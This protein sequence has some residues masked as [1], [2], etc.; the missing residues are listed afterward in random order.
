MVACVTQ[1]YCYSLSSLGRFV[2]VPPVLK[3]K[4]SV[5]LPLVFVRLFFRCIFVLDVNFSF[6]E[7]LNLLSFLAALGFKPDSAGWED[8][9]AHTV[10]WRC[11]YVGCSW[12]IRFS[13]KFLLSKFY[14]RAL[15]R[16]HFCFNSI[17]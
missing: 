13:V 1:S 12:P 9:H 8:V 15:K 2:D 16:Q 14:L 17:C 4:S 11:V 6:S 5:L 10:G 3:T 7:I